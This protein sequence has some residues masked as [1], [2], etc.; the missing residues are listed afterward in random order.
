LPVSFPVQIIYRIV[1]YRMSSV[2]LS[3]E[4]LDGAVNGCIVRSVGEPGTAGAVAKDGRLSVG[5]F[6]VGV[7][8]D[9]LRHVTTA[10][11][12]A[13]ILRQSAMLSSCVTY[14]R[15]ASSALLAD[16]GGGG[17]SWLRPPPFGRRTD[18]VTVLLI[19]DNVTV[20][21]PTSISL[22]RSRHHVVIGHVS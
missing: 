9:N 21:W 14:V 1:S 11:A 7:N 4:A 8:D 16:L 19:S 17:A 12:H 18:A 2:G 13:A 22:M 10:Q 5:D 15:H 6:V 3:V 20:L